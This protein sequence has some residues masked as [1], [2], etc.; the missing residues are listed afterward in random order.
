MGLKIAHFP[1]VKTLDDF[2]FKASHRSISASGGS[3][4][5]VDFS[6]MPKTS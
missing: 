2:D 1:T 3:S 6:P 5:P 4:L